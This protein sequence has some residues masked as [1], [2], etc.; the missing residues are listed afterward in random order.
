VLAALGRRLTRFVGIGPFAHV[1]VAVLV[2][3]VIVLGLYLVPVLGLITYKLTGIL[4]LGVVVYTLAL[5]A[6]ARRES[7]AAPAFASASAAPSADFS[8]TVNETQAQPRP[9]TPPPSTPTTVTTTLPRAGFWIRMAALL[10][11]IILIG[12]IVNVV[13]D[14][15]EIFL[16]ALAAYGAIMWK[17]KGTTVGG[18][19]CNLR[20]VRTD[21][22]EIDWPT[23]IVRAL[24]CFLS[25]IIAGLGFLWI[26]F[27]SERQAWHDKIAGTVVVRAPQSGALV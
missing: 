13:A 9:E 16:L 23:A 6:K 1:A 17:L 11:D 22:R 18:I 2:G 15:G 14:S 20:V 27:D 8:G 7:V 4:G 21:G 10:I 3:G 24:G 19:V 12:V 5:A 25:L 26:V